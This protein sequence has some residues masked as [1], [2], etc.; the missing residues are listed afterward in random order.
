ILLLQLLCLF[1]SNRLYF[2]FLFNIVFF[3]LLIPFILQS[4]HYFLFLSFLFEL[5]FNFFKRWNIFLFLF[6]LVIIIFQFFLCHFQVPKRI[7]I[8][9]KRE[10]KP[11]LLFKIILR[12]VILL[13]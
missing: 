12:H 13:Q 4:I 2:H 11:Q 5:L 3:P 7:F 6:H 1:H 9:I 8:L 10:I